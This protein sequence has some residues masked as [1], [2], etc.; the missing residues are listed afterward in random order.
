[1]TMITNSS[2]VPLKENLNIEISI[3]QQPISQLIDRGL[4]GDF[5]F[6][7]MAYYADYP[8][9]ENFLWLFWGKK[10]PASDKEKSYPNMPRFKNIKYDEYYEKGLQGIL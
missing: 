10:V 1:M 5:D 3:N 6:M 7:R 2:S 4:S 8:S 9:P